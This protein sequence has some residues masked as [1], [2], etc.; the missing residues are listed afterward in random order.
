MLIH[1]K[2]DILISH[3]HSEILY[4]KYLEKP[5][6][7]KENIWLILIDK[8]DHINIQNILSPDLILQY[9]HLSMFVLTRKIIEDEGDK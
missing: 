2:N 3:R 5:S 1:G 6:N 9:S 7:K 8:C 4:N